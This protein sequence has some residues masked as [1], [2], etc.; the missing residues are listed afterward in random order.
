MNKPAIIIQMEGGIIQQILTAL[1]EGERPEIVVVDY[2]TEGADED[3][4]TQVFGNP[5][6][7]FKPYVETI[8]EENAEG[9]CN[10]V[11]R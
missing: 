5:A 10:A 2:D 7:V 11:Q 8:S 1:P 9:V 3:E 6:F 4:T